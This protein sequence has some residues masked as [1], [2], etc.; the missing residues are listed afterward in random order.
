MHVVSLAIELDQLALP[1]KERIEKDFSE[2]LFHL[3]R[4]DLAPVF[5]YDN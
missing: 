4:D 1:F 3:I 2:P 5:G